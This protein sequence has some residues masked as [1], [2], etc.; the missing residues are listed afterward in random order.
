MKVFRKKSGLF[1]GRPFNLCR[2]CAK[3]YEMKKE[4]VKR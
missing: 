2:K 1:N 3:E 4:D